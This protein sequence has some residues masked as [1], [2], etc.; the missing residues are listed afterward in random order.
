MNSG[1]CF[2]QA[3]LVP[4]TPRKKGRK[5]KKNQQRKLKS[6]AEKLITCKDANKLVYFEVILAMMIN[7]SLSVDGLMLY[8]SIHLAVMA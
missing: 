1:S 8:K 6:V 7:F 5:F 2:L 3:I 4:A